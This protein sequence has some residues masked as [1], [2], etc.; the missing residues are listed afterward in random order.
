MVFVRTTTCYVM[1]KRPRKSSAP[2]FG[3][4]LKGAPECRKN[5]D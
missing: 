4:G 2:H 5:A 3:P 1:T